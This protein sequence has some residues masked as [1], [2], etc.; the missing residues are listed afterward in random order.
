MPRANRHFL[1]GHVWHIT[2]RY[3]GRF[4]P[5]VQVVQSLRFVPV[6][7]FEGPYVFGRCRLVEAIQ[8]NRR[9]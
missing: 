4:V 7:T 1:P 2:H 5:N 6:L 9:R 8:F 3:H